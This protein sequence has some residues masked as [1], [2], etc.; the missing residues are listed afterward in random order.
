M[1]CGSCLSTPAFTQNRSVLYPVSLVLNF[2]E[3]TVLDVRAKRRRRPNCDRKVKGK[4]ASFRLGRDHGG[5]G[6]ALGAPGYGDAENTN[7]CRNWPAC[8]AGTTVRAALTELTYKKL[9]RPDYWQ[10][11]LHSEC[12][13]HCRFLCVS[14]GKGRLLLS[15]IQSASISRSFYFSWRNSITHGISIG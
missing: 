8:T 6:L 14:P 5:K 1:S 10:H 3:R 12:S 7:Y 4:A 15:L 2:G 11:R 13:P 9:I